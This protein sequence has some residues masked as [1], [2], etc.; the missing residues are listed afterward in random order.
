M[1]KCYFANQYSVDNLGYKPGDDANR[2]TNPI[3]ALHE[4]RKREYYW[5]AG[6]IETAIQTH[7]S[8]RQYFLN[9]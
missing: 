3:R 5:Q 9:L 2:V 7:S 6:H 8:F 4:S 1:K